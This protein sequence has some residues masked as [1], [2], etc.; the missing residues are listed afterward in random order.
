MEKIKQKIWYFLQLVIA[1]G[2]IVYILLQVDQEKFFTYFSGID[3]NRFLII[4]PFSIV[5]LYIQFL[6][7]KY[8]VS[9]YSSHFDDHDLIPS[10]FAG[11]TLR[12][13][14]PGG[15]A[16]ISKIYLLPGKKKGKAIAFGMERYFQ[17]L[18]KVFLIT[19]VI[20]LHFKEYTLPAILLL[21]G[22]V[23]LYLIFP[24]L[25]VFDRHLEKEVSHHRVFV[26][27]LLFAL[28]LFFIMAIQ[29]FILLNGVYPI[30][31]LDTSQTVVF[32]WGAGVIPISISGL[33]IREGLAAFFLAKYGFDPAYAVATSLFLFTLNNIFPAIMGGY[34]LY[35]RR[36]HFN[37]VRS[38]W[39]Q[40]W[41]NLKNGS[42]NNISP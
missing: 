32:L 10:F 20:P 9:S 36:T 27:N 8:L 12:L 26:M 29:Y 40:F 5:G 23:V 31:F 13:L 15:H 1:V 11:F 7:W 3:L 25:S 42:E 14:V 33:G 28:I 2:L 16:E 21:V 41:R 37:E 19:L 17:T 30:S 4:I 34:Y 38:T 22:L 35:H 18:I 39:Q 6:R 24:R